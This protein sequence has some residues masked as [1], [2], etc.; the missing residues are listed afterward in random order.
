MFAL[1]ANKK[2]TFN[3]AVN[4]KIMSKMFE[5]FGNINKSNFIA[6]YSKE[7]AYNIKPYNDG[8]VNSLYHAPLKRIGSI[9]YCAHKRLR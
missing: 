9:H 5:M 2:Y 4:V 6:K 7:N 1:V 8:K 3:S